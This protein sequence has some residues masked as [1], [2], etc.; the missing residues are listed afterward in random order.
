[1]A[2]LSGGRIQIA[3]GSIALSFNSLAIAIRYTLCRRQFSAPKNN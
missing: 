3:Y 1:M 2:A